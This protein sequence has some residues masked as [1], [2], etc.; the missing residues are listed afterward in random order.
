MSPVALPALAAAVVA[1]ATAVATLWTER[2]TRRGLGMAGFLLLFGAAEAGA[3]VMH[4]TPA[5]AEPPLAAAKWSYVMGILAYLPMIEFLGDLARRAGA[6][7]PLGIPLAMAESA[8]RLLC[9]TALLLVAGGQGAFAGIEYADGWVRKFGSSWPILGAIGFAYVSWAVACWNGERRRRGRVDADLATW[10]AAIVLLTAVPIVTSTLLPATGLRLNHLNGIATV[11]GSLAT[12]TGLV[13]SRR[14][15]LQRLTPDLPHEAFDLPPTQPLMPAQKVQ[16]AATPPATAADTAAADTAD[17]DG[18]ETTQDLP[19]TVEDDEPTVEDA[20]PPTFP[21]FAPIVLACTGC[22]AQYRELPEDAVCP[23]DGHPVQTGP[24]PLIGRVVAG[25]WR[26]LRFLG[27]GGMARV[28]AAEHHR[29]GSR[30]ALKVIWG[31]LLSDPK[32]F[33]RFLREANACQGLRS[34][35]I[36]EIEDVLEIQPGLP[37]LVLELVEGESFDHVLAETGK[38]PVQSAALLGAQLAQGLKDAHGAGIV[39]RDLKPANVMVVRGADRDLAKIV[40]FGLARRFDN[41]AHD[42]LTRTGTVTGTPA[43]LSPEQILGEP[44]T[45]ASDLYALGIM[46][47]EVLTGRRPFHGVTA[48]EVCMMHL[49]VPPDPTPVEGPLGDIVMGLLEKDPSI[50]TAA[51]PHLAIRLAALAGLQRRIADA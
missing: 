7:R 25:T 28:Y 15:E 12:V 32:S 48:Q 41:P 24:D 30:C 23:Q 8:L 14:L 46:L 45:P 36:I 16:A 42:K 27:A 33:E 49:R 35:H 6:E 51:S 40:D 4:L 34:K 39:H 1:P 21:T 44:P 22:K 43:Y 19:R 2:G 11:L 37:A 5:D 3:A 38:L 10:L 26:I 13:M 17:D 18:E 29:L 9:V 20:G 31:D 47:Y 50:R